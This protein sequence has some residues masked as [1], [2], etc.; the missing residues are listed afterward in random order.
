MVTLELGVVVYVISATERLKQE[1]FCEFHAD[2]SYRLRP[3]LRKDQGRIIQAG[4][5]CSGQDLNPCS[6]T[7]RP[8]NLT[9]H[10]TRYTRDV[11]SP[12]VLR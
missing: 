11:S 7:S 4:S 12:R 3:Y 2:Q 6:M 9:R 5:D 10:D 1:N 8:E